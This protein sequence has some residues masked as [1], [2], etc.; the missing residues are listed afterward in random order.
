MTI[1]SPPVQYNCV[2]RASITW[3]P[4]VMEAISLSSILERRNDRKSY[5]TYSS[6]HSTRLLQNQRTLLLVVVKPHFF[7]TIEQCRILVNFSLD[8]RSFHSWLCP[9]N[10][11]I[12]KPPLLPPGIYSFQQV[13]YPIFASRCHLNSLLCFVMYVKASN[14]PI[15]HTTRYRPWPSPALDQIRD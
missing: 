9:L 10:H 14:Y 13:V 12:C 3:L 2:A 4:W 7:R 15:E 1:L 11:A 5:M 8:S 6:N